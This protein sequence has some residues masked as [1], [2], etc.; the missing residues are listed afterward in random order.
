MFVRIAGTEIELPLNRFRKPKF[1]FRIR[2]VASGESGPNKK[3]WQTFFVVPMLVKP[4]KLHQNLQSL[5]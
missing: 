1:L 5:F 3:P 4:F 2:E